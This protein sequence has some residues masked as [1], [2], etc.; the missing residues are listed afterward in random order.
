M[1]PLT[2][3]LVIDRERRSG[4]GLGSDRESFTAECLR[5]RERGAGCGLLLFIN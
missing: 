5:V 1:S 4:T 3:G 2:T